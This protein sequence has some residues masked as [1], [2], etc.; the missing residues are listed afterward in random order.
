MKLWKF[1]CKKNKF[2]HVGYDEYDAVVVLAV[3][4][5]AAR[6]LLANAEVVYGFEL[7]HAPCEEVD[8]TKPGIVLDS[9][10]AG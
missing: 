6:E 2:D 10:C 7:L 5:E 9:F 1:D 8:L 4:E 3:S